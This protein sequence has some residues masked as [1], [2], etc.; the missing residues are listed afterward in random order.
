MSLHLHVQDTVPGVIGTT[1]AGGF[2]LLGF[3]TASLPVL[4][5]ISLVAGI[6]VAIITFLYYLKRIR[7]QDVRAEAVVAA[8]VVK[9][10]AKVTAAALDETK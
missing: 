4:Q 10:A 7:A 5:F 2:T 3:M 8:Q 9:A 6:A 1:A